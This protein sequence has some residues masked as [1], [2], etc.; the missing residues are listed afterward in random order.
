[1][2]I[3]IDAKKLRS[4]K[5]Y[6]TPFKA[7]LPEYF[8]NTLDAFWDFLT[9]DLPTGS[10]IRLINVPVKQGV[11]IKN[12]VAILKELQEERDDIKIEIIS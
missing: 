10:H 11:V 12:M 1:M 5:D 8:G 4:R 9:T 3:T 6:Y 2:N 7:K